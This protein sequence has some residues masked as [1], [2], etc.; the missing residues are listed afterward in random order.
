MLAAIKL[1][2]GSE[3][4]DDS[5]ELSPTAATTARPSPAAPKPPAHGRAIS[6][7]GLGE[8]ERQQE[9]DWV[10]VRDGALRESL[11]RAQAT[12]IERVVDADEDARDASETQKFVADEDDD[13]ESGLE[14][15]PAGSFDE[16]RVLEV[17]GRELAEALAANFQ[18]AAAI[19]ELIA[20][21]VQRVRETQLAAAKRAERQAKVRDALQRGED[22]QPV[23]DTESSGA[24]EAPELLLNEVCAV[25]SLV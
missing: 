24:E 2:G 17:L 13:S 10:D 1:G 18:D 7:S 20:T 5:D 23:H 25:C 11:H 14:A 12:A 15:L 19:S 21:V 6:S 22:P 16:L 3:S 8:V 9:D 4:K